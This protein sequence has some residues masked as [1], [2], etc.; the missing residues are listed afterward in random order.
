VFDSFAGLPRPEGAD[1]G[2]LLLAS[3]EVHTYSEGD[4][5]G[6]LDVVQAN[7]A[8]FG[9]IDRCRFH[10]GYFADTLP[11][12]GSPV[13]F[14]YLDVD[15]VKSE[16][17]CIEYLWPLLRPG[18]FVFT[19]EAQHHEMAQLFYD[20]EWW[21]ERLEEEPPGLVGAGNG[22]GLFLHRGGFRSGLGYTAKVDRQ[23]LRSRRG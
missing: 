21:R 19:D 13:V 7:V 1:E 17:T 15:L 23:A 4:Y 20:K 12:F 22:V 8:R 16:E 18:C 10:A 14:A 9:A 5:R 11:D 3:R 6:S 2:H